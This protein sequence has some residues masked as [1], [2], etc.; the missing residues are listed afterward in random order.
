MKT[1]TSPKTRTLLACATFLSV[2]A[3]LLQPSYASDP[4][5]SRAWAGEQFAQCLQGGST[6]MFLD[7]REKA[8]KRVAACSN[9]I[10]SGKLTASEL[11]LARLARGGARTAIGES[12][13]AG[14]DYQEA[15]RHYDSAID[16]SNPEALALYRRGVARFGLGQT[17]RALADLTAAI[18]R[19]PKEPLAFFER[20]V[21]LASRQRAY[22]RA[23]ADFDKVL[24][25]SPDN[26]GALLRRGDA[27]GQIND[28][29]HA[30]A[31]LDRAIL[32]APDS[33]EARV[34]RGVTRSRQAANVLALADYSEALR[35]DPRNTEAL[36]NRAALY[37]ASDAADLALRDL[38]AAIAIQKTAPLAYYN[39][40]YVHFA[41]QNYGLAID[42]YSRAIAL[43]PGMGLAYNNRCL[44]RTIVGRDL[45]E[46]L[47]DC[48]MAL[49][50]RPTNLEVRET[51]GFIYLKLGDPAIAIVEYN[52]VLEIDP[53]RP[54]ALYGRG[55]A[56][57]K[58]GRTQEG[59]VDQAAARALDPSIERRFTIYGVS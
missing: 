29:G 53:N 45:I 24:A 9:A 36:V 56:R 33:A 38:D 10:Q 13:L 5:K 47:A 11:G 28:F 14:G 42:D 52:A 50:A 57:I 37:A 40:G 15:L 25:L 34:Y 55:L 51:R 23:I 12:I 31:D 46:A 2:A 3:A 8:E 18:I 16:P 44:A 43:D 20:G 58:L 26:V 48:D 21:V 6:G 1:C 19:D 4:V 22:A 59:E 7:G 39:R 41:K 49:K 30:L 54:L 27:Y 32:L 35:L 17:E